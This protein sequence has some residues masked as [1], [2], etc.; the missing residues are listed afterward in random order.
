MSDLLSL[1]SLASRSMAAQQMGLGVVGQNMANANTPGYARREV[2]LVS[3]PPYGATSAGDGVD[4]QGVTSTRDQMIERQLLLEQPAEERESALASSLGVVETSLG[5]SGQ[6]VDSQLSAFFNA[7]STLSQD[8]TSST[9]RQGVL[10]QGQSLATAFNNMAA[11]FQSERTDADTGIRNAVDQVNALAQQIASLNQQ[12]GQSGGASTLD[13]QDQETTAVESLSKLIDVDVIKNASG[14]ED[15]SI[16]N[17]RALVIGTNTYAIGVTTDAQGYADLQAGGVSV[18]NEITG[19]QIGGL[20]QARDVLIPGYQSQ[21]DA[22]AYGVAQQVNAAHEAGYTLNGNGT[23]GSAFFTPLTTQT[24]AAAALAVNP[25]VAA[26]TDLVA[27]ASGTAGSDNGNANTIAALG[28]AKV[29]D[30]NTTSFTDAWAGLVYQVGQ[31]SA[32]AQAEQTSRGE[33]VTQINALQSSVSGVSLDEEATMLT[34]F[35]RA[36]EASAEYF[37]AVNTTISTLITMLGTTTGA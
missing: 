3:V 20:L 28:T 8:P 31:D 4:V 23:H 33:I 17:G 26:N 25:T 21:L 35:Q 30:G 24:G 9:A 32:N 1:L 22:I 5:T 10:V 13:L 2:T 11:S 29:L 7:W 37:T 15:V 16:A 12:I 6:S 36:Y 19:G 18:T 14:G 27:A 34:K